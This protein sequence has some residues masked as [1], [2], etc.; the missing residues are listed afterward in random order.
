MRKAQDLSPWKP[1]GE[2]PWQ[3]PHTNN[4]SGTTPSAPQANS[5]TPLF[6]AHGFSSVLAF[7]PFFPALVHLEASQF[8]GWDL[9]GLPICFC[10]QKAKASG[11]RPAD[12][13]RCGQGPT[14]IARPAV[15]ACSQQPPVQGL[16]YH[17]HLDFGDEKT[18]TQ[19]REVTCPKS[20]NW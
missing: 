1:Q 12:L 2:A 4:Q 5:F 13:T 16:Q 20:D 11:G 14:P 10:S 15:T 3:G 6:Y 17:H 7:D 9:P 18:D 8:P 19:R